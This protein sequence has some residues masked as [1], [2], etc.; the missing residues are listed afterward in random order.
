MSRFEWEK[1]IPID[2]AKLLLKLCEKGR[3]FKTR[4]EVLNG[5]FTF[6]IDVF[7]EQNEGL[8]IAEIELKTEMDVL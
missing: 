2:E 8:I 6:E 3:I 1:E 4:Y 7:H 5:E